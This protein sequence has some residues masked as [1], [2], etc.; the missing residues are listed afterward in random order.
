MTA[1]ERIVQFA[2]P[3][4]NEEECLQSTREVCEMQPLVML[5]WLLVMSRLLLENEPRI[6]LGYRLGLFRF[7]LDLGRFAFGSLCGQ[8]KVVNTLSVQG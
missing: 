3:Y 6:W 2:V 7:L 8:R 5:G 4:C 1:R